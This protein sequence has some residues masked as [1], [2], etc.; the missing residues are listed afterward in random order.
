MNLALTRTE[1]LSTGIFG[2]L[3]SEDDELELYTIEHAYATQPDGT[4][5]SLVYQPKVPQ[6][7]YTCVRGT[8]ALSNG[9]AFETFEITNVPGHT[10]VLIHPG[11]S[12]NDSHGCVLLGLSRSGDLILHSKDAFNKFMKLQTGVNEFKLYIS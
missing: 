7:A 3:L 4:V 9:V 10:G 6:G 8:H 5:G 1:Y 2:L 11:N 12:E